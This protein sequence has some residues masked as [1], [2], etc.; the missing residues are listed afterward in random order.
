MWALEWKDENL[1]LTAAAKA[2]WGP[3]PQLASLNTWQVRPPTA[4]PRP[5]PPHSSEHSLLTG[6]VCDASTASFL[7]FQGMLL[8]RLTL[9]D[10]HIF[11]YR[12]LNL[13]VVKA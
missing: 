5:P 7:P 6:V 8:P 11:H 1:E 10:K 2:V 3:A 9:N 12:T 4:P 13:M